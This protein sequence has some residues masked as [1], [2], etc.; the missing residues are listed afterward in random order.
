MRNIALRLA[1]DGTEF[2]G[3]QWQRS[4]RTV[5]GVLEQAWQQLTQENRRFLLA[6][7]TDAGVH[8]Q[9]QVAN[10]QSETYHSLATIHRA[11]NA[12]LPDDVVVQYVWEAEPDFHARFRAVRRFYRYLIEPAA[13]MLPSLRRYVLHHAAPLDVEAMREALAVLEGHH[14]FAAFT[15]LK[16]AERS[17]ERT[18]YEASCHYVSCFG[19]SLLAVDLVANAF[20]HHMVRMI[21]GTLL[22]VGRGQLS[23]QDVEYIVQRQERRR[24]GPTAAA[25][26]LTLMAVIYPGD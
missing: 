6:G 24:V 18:C 23:V 7:R 11:L 16:A 12:L 25:H 4:G 3:S 14:D 2:V 15:S 17:T 22:L 9:G 21:V 26:G 10:I 8:A 19:R 5:Q 13:W 1:Y 20:L